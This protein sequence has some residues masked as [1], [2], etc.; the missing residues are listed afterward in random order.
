MITANHLSERFSLKSSH[1]IVALY[2]RCNYDGNFEVEMTKTMEVE[3][4]IIIIYL[5]T[6]K[7]F[8]LRQ[9]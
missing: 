7:Y 9:L 8:L 3:I 1:E 5:L 4:I 2:I 6:V